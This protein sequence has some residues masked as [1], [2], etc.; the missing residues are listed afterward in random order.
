[1]TLG[2][3]AELGAGLAIERVHALNQPHRLRQQLQ[4]ERGAM[5]GHPR[6]PDPELADTPLKLIIFIGRCRT[7]SPAR[8]TDFQQPLADDPLDAKTRWPHRVW[9]WGISAAGGGRTTPARTIGT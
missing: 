5:R 3:R 6:E 2:V 1:M 8:V 9:W 7:I 4:S